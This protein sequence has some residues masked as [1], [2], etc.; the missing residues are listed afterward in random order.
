MKLLV[1]VTITLFSVPTVVLATRAPSS[2]DGS[3]IKISV[4]HSQGLVL[5]KKSTVSAG[6]VSVPVGDCISHHK[7]RAQENLVGCHLQLVLVAS[8]WHSVKCSHKFR[9]SLS[10]LYFTSVAIY[11][12]ERNSS[13][14]GRFLYR[15]TVVQVYT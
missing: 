1:V 13:V 2:S 5:Y 15:Y 8:W 14:H 12:K 10:F 7:C 4:V 6:E 11:Y 3:M 9:Y